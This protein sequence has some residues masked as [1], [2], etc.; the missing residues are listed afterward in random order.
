[1]EFISLLPAQKQRITAFK[2]IMSHELQSAYTEQA[3]SVNSLHTSIVNSGKTMLNSAIEAGQI[4]EQ[5]RKG[6][7]HGQWFLWLESNVRFS[8]QTADNYRKLAANAER[9]RDQNLE[10]TEAYKLLTNGSSRSERKPKKAD[11]IEA[12]VQVSNAEDTD[13]DSSDTDTLGTDFHNLILRHTSP[14]LGYDDVVDAVQELINDHLSG[15][16]RLV[17]YAQ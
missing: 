5:V 10:L 6:L 13:N 8:R 4:L 3:E 1:M 9:L 11:A 14:A 7:P 12:E 16:K 2:H 17:T 15:L